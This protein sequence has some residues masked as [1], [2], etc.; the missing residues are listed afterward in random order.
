MMK[1]FFIAIVLLATFN[2]V[3]AQFSVLNNTPNAVAAVT[4][5]FSAKKIAEKTYEL[6]MTATIINGFH[7]YAQV[8]NAEGPVPTTFTFIKSPL[9]TFDGKVKENGTLISKLEPV[10]GFKVNYFENK[11]D[12]VQVVQSKV[13]APSEVKGKVN[14]MVCNDKKCLP[15]RD[16]DFDIKIGND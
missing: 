8:N 2:M 1:K 16:V 9:L 5:V 15:P 4:W 7:L 13:T 10:W 11:V 12:F 3:D 14:F 6:H